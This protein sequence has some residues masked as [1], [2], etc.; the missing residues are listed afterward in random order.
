[1]YVFVFLISTCSVYLSNSQFQFCTDLVNKRTA[2]MLTK[3]VKTQCLVSFLM[4]K[5]PA[6]PKNTSPLIVSQVKFN[7]F[8]HPNEHPQRIFWYPLR[9]FEAELSKIGHVRVQS[10]FSGPNINWIFPEMIFLSEYQIRRTTFI[11]SIFTFNYS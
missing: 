11:N 8:L 1:M 5:K 10:Q 2:E 3:F 4:S 6:A 7:R 9:R